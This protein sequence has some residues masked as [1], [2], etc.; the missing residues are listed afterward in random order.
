M[1]KKNWKKIIGGLYKAR[2]IEMLD[3]GIRAMDEGD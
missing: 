3:D 1:S 2:Q